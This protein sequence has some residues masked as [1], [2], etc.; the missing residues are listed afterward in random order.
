MVNRARDTAHAGLVGLTFFT[1]FA[2]EAWRNLIGWWGYLALGG[3]LIVAWLIIVLR[4]RRSLY[5]RAFTPSLAVF[6]AWLGLSITWSHYPDASA[7]GWAA[8]LATTFL[9]LAIVL[10]TDRAQL[11]RGLGFALRW[12]LGL[13]LIFE[14][15]VA[16]FVRQPV[17]PLWVDWGTSDVPEAFFWSQDRLLSLG[18]IQ[19][20]V[21]NRNLLGFIAL[22]ALGSLGWAPKPLLDGASEVSRLCL[23]AAMAALGMKTSFKKLA[24]VGWRPIGLMVLETAW[25]AIL[26]L[27]VVKVF[28]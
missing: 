5:W 13:S 18:P 15:T 14:A 3:V 7:L 27:I 10:T 12:I 11:I 9:A 25:I 8:T 2:S 19:G 4:A 16:L 26:V 6:L 28:V 22:V 17:L 23:I 24:A 20:I 21:G 1:L